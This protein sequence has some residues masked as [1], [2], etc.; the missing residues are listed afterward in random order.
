MDKTI[1]IGTRESL[2]AVAQAELVKRYLET[3]HPEYQVTLVKMKTAGDRILDRSLDQIG[4]KGLFVK[5][6]DMALYEN[7]TDLSVHSLKDLPMEVPKDLPVLGYSRRETPEDAL[8]LPSGYTQPDLK[9]PIGTS[10]PRRRVQL[11]RLYPGCQLC[12]VRGNIVTRLQKLDSGVCGALVLAAAGLVRLNLSHR[13]SRLFSTDEMVPAAGQG[14]L[15]VQAREDFDAGLLAGF[16]DADAGWQALA[17]RSFVRALGGG[18]ASPVA[19]YASIRGAQMTLTGL[20]AEEGERDAVRLSLTAPRHE[21]EQ[22]GVRLA[23]K[24]SRSVRN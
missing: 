24:I 9:K 11:A 8:V 1:R 15:A 16:F 6:L 3:A 22:L 14:I 17:E 18:C 7:R 10:S 4:G 5:E 21:A 12:P 20:L 23:E 13:I 19:A 2:L